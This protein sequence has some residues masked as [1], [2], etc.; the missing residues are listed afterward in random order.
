MSEFYNY[1]SK[2]LLKYMS[3]IQL[4]PGDR[5][6]LQLDEDAEVN[7]LYNSLKGCSEILG[8]KCGKFYTKNSYETYYIMINRVKLLIARTDINIKSDY[9]T[10]LRN[11]VDKKGTEFENT[12]LLIIHNSNL[13]SII[14]GSKRLES[15]GMPFN[16]KSIEKNILKS[17]DESNLPIKDKRIL[18]IYITNTKDNIHELSTSI[19]DFEEVFNILEQSYIKPDQ[20]KDFGM[21]MDD[22]LETFYNTTK[23]KT[24]DKRIM[25]NMEIFNTVDSIHKYSDISELEQHFDSN[26]V[27]KLINENWVHIEYDKVVKSKEN[28]DQQKKPVFLENVLVNDNSYIIWD[29]PDGES[30]AQQRRRNMIVFN[31]E[32]NNQV[33]IVLRFNL[34]IIKEEVKSTNKNVGL[35]TNNTRLV[36]KFNDTEKEV[37]A[38]K[39]SYYNLSFNIITVNIDE[40]YLNTIKNKYLVN[41]NISKNYKKIVIVSDQENLIFNHN[42]EHNQELE[43]LDIDNKFNISSMDKVKIINNYEGC[44]DAENISIDLIVDDYL[45]P[46]LIKNDV[47]RPSKITSYQVWSGKFIKKLNY[48]Y[49]RNFDQSTKKESIDITQDTRSFYPTGEFRKYLEIEEKILKSNSLHFDIENGKLI[50]KSL[51]I[52]QAIE[53]T[54]MELFDF[55]KMSQT[56]PSLISFTDEYKSVAN[57]F[58]DG[59]FEFLNQVNNTYVNDKEVLKSV[60]DIGVIYEYSNERKIHFAPWHPMNLAY[61]LQLYDKLVDSD[62]N[63]DI[64]SY[65]NN[66]YLVPYIYNS[67]NQLF[68]PIDQDIYEWTTYVRYDNSKYN[69]ANKYVPR[70]V[71]NKIKD[72]VTHFKYLFMNRIAPLKLGLV[73]LGDCEE[74]LKGI[75]EYYISELRNG[76]IEDLRPIEIHVYDSDNNITAFEELSGYTNIDEIKEIFELKL[77]AKQYDEYDILNAYRSKVQFYKYKLNEISYNHITFYKMDDKGDIGNNYMFNIETGLS[78][79]GLVTDVSST[80]VN[81]AYVTG[82]GSKNLNQENDSFI[83]RVVDFNS[84]T[85]FVNKL[86]AFDKNTVIATAIRDEENEL[87]KSIYRKSY[88]ITF[89]DPKVDLNYFKSN[90]KAKDLMIIHYSDQYSNSSGYDAITVTQKSKMYMKAIE[91]FLLKESDIDEIKLDRL[92]EIINSFNVFNG[93]WLLRLVSRQ[94]EQKRDQFAREKLSLFSAVKLFLANSLANDIIWIPISSEELVRVS[95]GSGLSKSDTLLSPTSTGSFSDDILMI[96]IRMNNN[97]VEVSYYPIEVKIGNNGTDIIKKAKE[98]VIEATKHFKAS[99]FDKDYNTFY[100]KLLRNQLIQIAITQ[101]KKISMYGM[102]QEKDWIKI[103]GDGILK[104]LINDEYKIVERFDGIT[105]D[106]G[107]ITFTKN[108]I[109]RT[110]QKVEKEGY[111]IDYFDYPMHDVFSYLSMELSEIC[112]T[113]GWAVTSNQTQESSSEVSSSCNDQVTDNSEVIEP[114]ES[115]MLMKLE[116][117]S[118]YIYESHENRQEVLLEK[119]NTYNSEIEILFGENQLTKEKVLWLPN[120][121]DKVMHTN[122]GIIGTMGTGKTQFTK[123]L[124]TQL[125]QQ[126]VYNVDGQEIGILIFDYKGDYI[127]DDFVYA[128]GATVYEPD[129]LPFN[130]LSLYLGEKP[131]PK[132]PL[133]TANELR[134]T[135]CKAYNLGNVQRNTLGDVLEQAYESVGIS[136]KDKESWTKDAPTMEIVYNNYI[137]AGY[138]TNDSLYS[139]LRELYKFEIFEPD[140]HKTIALF[141]FIKGV[142][143]INLSGYS[144]SIQ[145]LVVAITLDTF[146]SQMQSKGHSKIHGNYR[147]ITRMILVDEADNFLG[148]DFNSIK[149]ILKEG[150]EFGVGTILSTQFLKH[151]STSDN[152]YSQYIL[153]WVIHKVN[154][155]S[156]REVGNIFS[157][158]NKNDQE[159]WANNIKNLEKHFSIV[160]LGGDN[161]PKH[162]RDKAFWEIVKEE[163]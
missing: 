156:N 39:I 113:N 41:T 35:K 123:S 142:T 42:G 40:G 122:T 149:K 21:F 81:G 115:D 114:S 51:I 43:L 80:F 152:E 163:I 95:G 84:F 33:E 28:Y 96:G 73:N 88:W 130:P 157:L 60:Y 32:K 8:Y 23:E 34:K 46:L 118:E 44:E 16:I 19:F 29:R 52:P 89:I 78:L 86:S 79:D 101:I 148:K 143:V 75:F 112:N 65:V 22:K 20:F 2:I 13:D 45:I 104:K 61:Q 74:I 124:I 121:S 76:K 107:V 99:I 55:Y 131:R 144:E 98:Q 30:K 119:E 15:E 82:F 160:N 128:T 111:T 47:V 53:S 58:L 68:K 50:E 150:R 10:F 126:E 103:L 154:E 162:I 133:H 146:Y 153:T 92:V 26:G 66:T 70:I 138:P 72:F 5:Y 67:E 25:D 97:E 145:N 77:Q 127:K 38:T 109:M 14:G 93:E 18:H 62:F 158:T 6:S 64:S 48:S 17:I 85:E 155:I 139:A 137:K 87:L 1:I 4:A 57:K 11:N 37:Q 161:E 9:L 12:A 56:L 7:N 54:L 159:S 116:D 147:Q 63:K 69:S 3:N 106:C 102:W 120:S 31:P 108:Q 91:E 117:H 100:S 59:Y 83:T 134:D 105:N 71:A 135:I 129:C 125:K 90:S 49:E 132:L 27:E 141:D 110:Y 94:L 36:V 151:F 24:L 140:P 136:I